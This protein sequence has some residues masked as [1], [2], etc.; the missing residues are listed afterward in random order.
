MVNTRK[1]TRVCQACRYIGEIPKTSG[2]CCPNSDPVYMGLD[3]HLSM[4]G[5]AVYQLRRVSRHRQEIGGLYLENDTGGLDKAEAVFNAMSNSI[6]QRIMTTGSVGPR[7]GAK[8][9]ILGW[10]SRFFERTEDFQS[11]AGHQYESDPK[12]TPTGSAFTGMADSFVVR[13]H[14]NDDEAGEP[15]F[16]IRDDLIGK[17][18][19]G[20]IILDKGEACPKCRSNPEDVKSAIQEVISRSWSVKLKAVPQ[21]MRDELDLEM[22]ALW[23][24]YHEAGFLRMQGIRESLQEMTENG[25]FKPDAV[26]G[27]VGGRLSFSID[28]VTPHGAPAPEDQ[29]MGTTEAAPLADAPI[30]GG[31]DSKPEFAPGGFFGADVRW[32]IPASVAWAKVHWMDMDGNT[33]KGFRQG[34]VQVGFMPVYVDTEIGAGDLPGLSRIEI[35][36]KDG[37]KSEGLIKTVT[38]DIDTSKF[39]DGVYQAELPFSSGLIITL[40]SPDK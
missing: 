5:K 9:G 14:A 27:E 25:V 29:A 6:F 13:D 34:Y 20:P 3:S 12:G 31:H 30:P 23:N 24:A 39:V 35:L 21:K 19:I 26:T 33:L 18:G 10:L 28:P 11:D 22:A 2:G 32:N 4:L 15:V 8:R 36:M 1:T 7:P 38:L 40:G 16:V 17:T 37:G